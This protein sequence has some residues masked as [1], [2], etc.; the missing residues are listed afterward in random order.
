MIRRFCIALFMAYFALPAAAFAQAATGTLSGTASESSGAPVVG[1]HVRISGP[2][3]VTTTTD[4]QGKFTATLSPGV[5]NID[6]DKGGYVPAHYTDVAIVAGGTL[7]VT[8]TL[9]RADLSTLRTIATVSTSRGSAINTGA[10][11]VSTINAEAIQNY[12]DPQINDLLQHV[13]DLTIQKMGSQ[14]DTTIVLGGAQPYETQVLIDGHPLALGQ[15]G[16]WLSEYFPSFLL[17]SVETQT[18]PGNTT[19]FA[20]TAV[21]GTANLVT[22][23]FTQAFRTEL[24]VGVDNYQSQYS[25]FLASGTLK[26]L[27]YVIGVGYGS[28]NGPYYQG[29]QC[30]VS[31]DPSTA[32]TGIVQFCGDSSGSLFNKGEVFK[33]R[34]NFSQST[35]FDVG[36]IGAQGGYLPQ[37]TGYGQYLGLMN[38]E[39]CYGVPNYNYNPAMPSTGGPSSSFC[40]NPNQSGLIGKTINAYAWYP[41]SN[42]YY[43]QPIF[44]GQLR[45]AIGNDT[46]LIRPYAGNI[47]FIVDGAG[48]QYYP[49]AFSPAGQSAADQNTFEN[50]CNSYNYLGQINTYPTATFVNGQEE[51]Y[52]TAFSELEQDKLYG[53]TVS[54]LHPFGESLLNFTYD[55]HGDNVF[56]YYNTPSD[57]A[58]PNTLERFT[59]ISVSGDLHVA[60]NIQLKVGLYD[61]LWHLTGSQPAPGSGGS[62]ALAGLDRSLSRFDPHIGLSF[63]PRGGISYRAAFGTSETYPFAGQVSGIPFDTPPSATFPGGYVTQKNPFLNPETAIEYSIGAD[64]R[65]RNNSVLS[66]DL[67]NTTIHNVFETLSTPDAF[68]NGEALVQPINAAKLVTKLAKISYRYDP[69]VGL[70]YN[71]AFAFESSIATGIPSS[72]YLGGAAIPANGQQI[73]GIGNA[74]PG[75]TTC[76]PYMK[77]YGQLTYRF[78][79]DTFIGLGDDF[80]GKNNTYFQPPFMQF[81]LTIRRPVNKNVDFQVSVQN[82]LNTNNFYNLPEP[83]QGTSQPANACTGVGTPNCGNLYL[84]SLPAVLVPAPPRTIRAELRIHG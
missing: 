49:F 71:V 63:Q 54:Y 18:G 44:T 73:C 82:L 33:L 77:G 45:T 56:A 39:P 74:T 1:A 59:T 50:A 58:V 61:T 10:A 29:N 79:D 22:D 9:A 3:N 60:R 78:K 37:G 67:Q 43:N 17:S 4:A 83:S 80:E 38:I 27:Q 69:R 51:C 42:I 64:K 23:P 5:Y 65:F 47:D 40:T 14:P 7:P 52:Q 12:P 19:P 26:K 16:V 62:G 76:I 34:Y 48:E 8:V 68:S 35:A 13:P 36:F 55:Y 11:S 84:T 31:P 57:V 20:N 6:V 32:G 30:V 70:G 41:G 53:T 2:Q 15:Y 46:L 28:N 75:T 81:D 66:L 21:G 72:F 24:T 25:H